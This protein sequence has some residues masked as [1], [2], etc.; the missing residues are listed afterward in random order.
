MKPDSHAWQALQDHAARQLRAGF[1]DDVLRSAHGPTA[2]VWQQLFA[3]GAGQLRVGFAERVLRAARN[4]PGGPS[5]F[6]QFIFSAG[7]AV[8]CAL[9]VFLIHS[10]NTEVENEQNL[11]SWQQIA[12]AAQEV[13][14]GL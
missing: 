4:I 10:H 6:E 9:A 14:A 13:G 11:A 12:M 8:V 5:Y 3:H 1:A 2:T 7:T